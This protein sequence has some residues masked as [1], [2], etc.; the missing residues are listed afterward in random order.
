MVVSKRCWFCI[1]KDGMIM[2]HGSEKTVFFGVETT[3]GGDP[4]IRVFLVTRFE[5]NRHFSGFSR[6]YS[7]PMV[8]RDL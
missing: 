4:V 7:H 6:H 3:D 2:Q 1:P 5:G 8:H